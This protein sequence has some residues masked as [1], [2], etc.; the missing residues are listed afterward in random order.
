M[1]SSSDLDVNGSANWSV[2]SNASCSAQG[3]LGLYRQ[4]AGTILFVL[5]WPIVVFDF[6][7]FPIGRPAAA[8][9]GGALMVIFYVVTQ[10]GAYAVVGRADS[11]QTLFLLIGMMML[12]HYFDREGVLQFVALRVLGR[13]GSSFRSVLWKVCFA[14]GCLA[15][16]ITNDAAC[17]VITP[18]LLTEHKRQKRNQKELWPL[19]LAVATS[20][21]IGSAATFFSNPQ[22]AF[23]A[24]AANTSLSQ[25][26][27][28]LF[29][30]ALLGLLLN[31]AFLYVYSFRLVC[32]GCGCKQ[33]R[34]DN[35]VTDTSTATATSGVTGNIRQVADH[36]DPNEEPNVAISREEFHRS[37]EPDGTQQSLHRAS[38]VAY[39]RGAIRSSLDFSTRVWE[40]RIP[41][42]FRTLP[43]DATK[44]A[45][46]VRRDLNDYGSF[47][48]A[49]SMPLPPPEDQDMG[50]AINSV[51]ITQQ[52]NIAASASESTPNL[53]E[54]GQGAENEGT[55]EGSAAGRRCA[56]RQKVTFLI[57]LTVISLISLILLMVPPQ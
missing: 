37:L 50:A 45:V 24:S 38:L 13:R 33:R 7:R 12:S 20:A 34:Q 57:W 26:L 17:L 15:A 22:N 36:E 47:S 9:L 18:L 6:K 28:S 29:P 52:I 19:C 3:H 1:L 25:F 30:A 21:N 35:P 55:D 43:R 27:V 48:R 44:S 14:T 53:A 8:L 32:V 23:I 10:D 51:G 41:P 42:H 16:L 2:I 31:T 49:Q 40:R 46:I 11:L 56:Q 54:E 5:V 4:V 39:E